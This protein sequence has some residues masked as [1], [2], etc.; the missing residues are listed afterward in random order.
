MK[1]WSA[2]LITT[3]L[4][5]NWCEQD[6]QNF[7]SWSRD[8]DREARQRSGMTSVCRS[9]PCTW[10]KTENWTGPDQL[11]LDWWLQLHAF[12][13][14]QPDRFGPVATGCACNTP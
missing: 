10:K 5:N 3:E 1:Y 2:K 9:G 11:G 14:T 13:T 7:I 6:L 12:Q 4:R 8:N